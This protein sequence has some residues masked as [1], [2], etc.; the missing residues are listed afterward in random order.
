[1]PECWCFPWSLLNHRHPT[2]RRPDTRRCAEFFTVPTSV[3][4][5]SCLWERFRW[6]RSVP[7]MA[8]ATGVGV[9]RPTKGL[10]NAGV[11]DANAPRHEAHRLD[12]KGRA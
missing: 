8:G 4:F 5:D 3:W 2:P 12:T 1:M 6:C 7:K 10:Q 9:V 11:V